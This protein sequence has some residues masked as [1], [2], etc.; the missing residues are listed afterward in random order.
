MSLLF[1]QVSSVLL[2]FTFSF[3]SFF[4]C[5]IVKFKQMINPNVQTGI[6]L[7]GRFVLNLRKL[8][9]SGCHVPLS[10]YINEVAV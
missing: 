9:T 1:V 5:G 10:F 8:L 3:C 6:C 7:S 4:M 2:D